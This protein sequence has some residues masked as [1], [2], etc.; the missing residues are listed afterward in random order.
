MAKKAKEAAVEEAEKLVRSPCSHSFN[1]KHGNNSAAC[2]STG[3]SVSVTVAHA[4]LFNYG[5]MARMKFASHTDALEFFLE[6]M[7]T[8]SRL[9]ELPHG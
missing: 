1:V 8:I 5:N 3:S 6:V 9:E 4:E 2:S 7:K